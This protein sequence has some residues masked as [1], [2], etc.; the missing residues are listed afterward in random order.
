MKRTSI[1]GKVIEQLITV[2]NVRNRI[3]SSSLEKQLYKELSEN[4]L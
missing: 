1:D 4:N 2:N 3:V